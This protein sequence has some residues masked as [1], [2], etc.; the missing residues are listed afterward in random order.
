MYS[1]VT[2]GGVTQG[3]VTQGRVVL[4]VFPR[5][6]TAGASRKASGGTQRGTRKYQDVEF[7]VLTVSLK[8]N[9]ILNRIRY[10]T[11]I[12]KAHNTSVN[13]LHVLRNRVRSI[14]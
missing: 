12:T 9:I 5:H 2:Q 6:K 8:Y 13:V 1:Q 4:P 7:E 11:V 14:T 3:R 10:R